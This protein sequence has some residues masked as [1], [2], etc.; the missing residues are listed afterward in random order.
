M[1][2]GL[3]FSFP[4]LDR[5]HT[6]FY[7]RSSF[8]ISFFLLDGEWIQSPQSLVSPFIVISVYA[9][10]LLVALK[11]FP[12][13]LLPICF[14][15]LRTLF[16][17]DFRRGFPWPL[18]RT[19]QSTYLRDFLSLRFLVFPL[20]A[21]ALAP[22]MYLSDADSPL[23]KNS[24]K[25]HRSLLGFSLRFYLS[26]SH[27]VFDLIF[28]PFSVPLVIFRAKYIESAL[29]CLFIFLFVG[30]FSLKAFFVGVCF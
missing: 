5:R 24:S 6:I 11:T 15:F 28:H 3:F 4:F 12:P 23:F 7:A 13:T 18:F 30:L 17:E 25:V 2:I 8:F 10:G 16:F 21:A 20:A 27:L 1:C 19:S 14:A 9:E 22:G 26:P 29:N